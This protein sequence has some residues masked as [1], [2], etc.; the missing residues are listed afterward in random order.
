MRFRFD[1]RSLGVSKMCRRMNEEPEEC[2][3]KGKKNVL[4]I[5]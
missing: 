3:T 2:V 4:D 1:D 5:H